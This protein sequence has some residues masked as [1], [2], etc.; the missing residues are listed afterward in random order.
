MHW[1]DFYLSTELESSQGILDVLH[2]DGHE[3]GHEGLEVVDGLVPL[4]ESVLVVGRHLAQ[5]HLQLPVAVL[6]QLLLQSHEYN[7][8]KYLRIAKNI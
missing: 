5:L 7:L 3:P 4:V 2:V 6:G 8:Q 1:H